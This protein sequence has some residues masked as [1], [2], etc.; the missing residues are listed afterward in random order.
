M[1]WD[2]VDA[3]AFVQIY[4]KYTSVIKSKSEEVR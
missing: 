3:N 2:R 4:E 1:G